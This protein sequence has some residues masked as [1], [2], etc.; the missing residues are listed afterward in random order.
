MRARRTISRRSLL[1][2]AP[3]GA[4]ATLSPPLFAIPKEDLKVR[5][6]PAG[7]P[8]LPPP[9]PADVFRN[10]Q[11]RV[12]ADARKRGLDALVVLP[13]TNYRY[14]TST[15]P[16][17]SER[18]IALLLRPGLPATVVA[19]FFEAERVGRD[20]VI[21]RLVPWQEDEDPAALAAKLLSGA[22]RIGL[23]GTTDV[24]TEERLRT[25]TGA[26]LADATA[27]FDVLRM[28]KSEP[29]RA[30]IRDAARRTTTAIAATQKRLREGLTEE[31]VGEMLAEEFRKA[32]TRGDGLVQFGASAALPHGAP[33]ERRLKGGDVVLMD[34]GCRV[35]GYSSD[36][37]RT[38]VF[39]TPFDEFRKVYAAV[40]AAQRAGFEAFRGGA[41]PEEVDRAARTVI[42]EAGYGRFFTHRLG[43]GLGLDGHEPPYLVR[44]NRTPLAAGNVCTIEPG[45]YLP[46]RFGVRIED[47]AAATADGN[48]LLSDRSP[49]LSALKP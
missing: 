30:L 34:C 41:I 38:A 3:A 13:S 26:S 12:L 32:G 7:A 6:T 31:E 27:V 10:R 44:G 24:R 4:L 16:G 42:E 40:E 18:L 29:E 48:E 21:G 49:G 9:L 17:R 35:H 5:E 20:A 36:I 15:D 11:E 1:V 14:L 28:V 2:A 22:K 23:E 19:P 46:G 45:I 43:H 33:G 39:G 25:A 37:T 47:D 8:P